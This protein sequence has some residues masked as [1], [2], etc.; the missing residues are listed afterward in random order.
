VCA[1]CAA[2]TAKAGAG[3]GQCT[4][5]PAGTFAASS[6]S[7]ECGACPEDTYADTLGATACSRC[8]TGS[9]TSGSEGVDSATEC[10]CAGEFYDEHLASGLG[11]NST[12]AVPRCAAC[13]ACVPGQERAVVPCSPSSN[14][15][16]ASRTLE[17]WPVRSASGSASRGSLSQSFADSKRGPGCEVFV[18]LEHSTNSR[19]D[20]AVGRAWFRI[21]QTTPASG[22]PYTLVFLADNHRKYRAMLGDVSG[23]FADTVS[24]QFTL[25]YLRLSGGQLSPNATDAPLATDPRWRTSSRTVT[26]GASSGVSAAG[27]IDQPGSSA[28]GWGSP[29]QPVSGPWRTVHRTGSRGRLVATYDNEQR[30]SD[31][32]V[33]INVRYYDDTGPAVGYFRLV[34]RDESQ[35]STAE[36]AVDRPIV[37]GNGGEATFS[38]GPVA[39][40]NSGVVVELWSLRRDGLQSGAYDWIEPTRWGIVRV[41]T[42][43][44]V[45]AASIVPDAG[46]NE[47]STS[48]T[49]ARARVIRLWDARRDSDG[50]ARVMIRWVEDWGPSRRSFLMRVFRANDRST[51][52]AERSLDLVNGFQ[53]VYTLPGVMPTDDID[54]VM[55]HE[56]WVPG[57]ANWVPSCSVRI[58]ADTP[59]NRVEVYPRIDLGQVINASVVTTRPSTQATGARGHLC[60]MYGDLRAPGCKVQVA[61]R[62][63]AGSGTSTCA[64]S[65]R[66][67]AIRV[68]LGSSAS[69]PIILD[70]A[71]QIRE[72]TEA[73]IEL[74]G[75]ERFAI[76]GSGAPRHRVELRYPDGRGGHRLDSFAILSSDCIQPF[77]GRAP[78]LVRL[79]E[80]GGFPLL[81]QTTDRRTNRNGRL[82]QLF[83]E[84]RMAD[85]SGLVGVNAM[86]LE[87]KPLGRGDVVVRVAYNDISGDDMQP[88]L[89]SSTGANAP[90]D[91]SQLLMLPR[92]SEAWVVFRSEKDGIS[93]SERP[94]ISL[95]RFD[96]TRD[97]GD[98]VRDG[99]TTVS[100][101]QFALGNNVIDH[102]VQWYA[103]ATTLDQDQRPSSGSPVLPL[104]NARYTGANG[105]MESI[106]GAARACDGSVLLRVTYCESAV[107]SP[108]GGRTFAVWEERSGTR[109]SVFLPNCRETA[110]V[111][112]ASLRSGRDLIFRLLRSD[113]RGGF[114][115]RGRT[116]AIMPASSDVCPADIMAAYDVVKA[117]L[118]S[119]NVGTG[120]GVLAGTSSLDTT[121]LDVHLQAGAVVT[122]S[123]RLGAI[124]NNGC[125]D[126]AGAS[127]FK[128]CARSLMRQL[129]AGEGEHGARRTATTESSYSNAA[130]A[131]GV[132]LQSAINSLA[133]LPAGTHVLLSLESFTASEDSVDAD[134]ELEPAPAGRRALARMPATQSGFTGRSL[135]EGTEG[136]PAQPVVGDA[137]TGVSDSAAF[138]VDEQAASSLSAEDSMQLDFRVIPASNTDAATLAV[139]QAVKDGTLEDA[140]RAAGGEITAL[141][142]LKSSPIA[143][144][145]QGI[146]AGGSTSS[147]SPAV[148][149]ASDNDSPTPIG[150]VLAASGLL[151]LAVAVAAVT[152]FRRRRAAGPAREDSAAGG[153][154]APR[155]SVVNR[156]L[157]RVASA[158]QR[159]S[160]AASAPAPRLAP[161]RRAAS[162]AADEAGSARAPSATAA[163]HEPIMTLTEQMAMGSDSSAPARRKLGPTRVVKVSTGAPS[164]G[165]LPLESEGHGPFSAV[166]TSHQ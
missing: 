104:P 152:A 123:R 87:Q 92:G 144:R 9:T 127:E 4:V 10:A 21:T 6:G 149:A 23:D 165:A 12:P 126:R 116:V 141:S 163:R 90:A 78:E 16:C 86:T 11:G 122:L 157:Q 2:G 135:Q 115:A 85:N 114:V 164:G 147:S 160:T 38:L 68:R 66:V 34:A 88:F 25:A 67:F 59:D 142:F 70:A 18:D 36:P 89:V 3:A 73:I 108:R 43:R 83:G 128:P 44:R 117:G 17:G 57:R 155:H 156:I 143:S 32:S 102:F 22:S 53:A 19:P 26:V 154:S 63:V 98:G 49:G 138:D 151:A 153:H 106:P 46:T 124:L 65:T 27:C 74:G 24:F 56:R 58:G 112:P 62:F 161:G 82:D 105:R 71:V 109:R 5:C 130:S 48:Q 29:L 121:V 166:G 54:V 1:S 76:H 37:V 110:I 159:S 52:L 162:S 69:S 60:G 47:P 139:S 107:S 8:P 72:G 145:V 50:A 119:E 80:A 81:A 134:D 45:S 77:K 118:L 42:L 30:D 140:I 84:R 125:R 40:C 91:A 41:G 100:T 79:A 7:A 39:C 64:G 35:P 55:Y 113:G 158:M 51:P 33:K 94:R 146:G 120:P 132:V 103:A 28:G 137:G 15:V 14:R 133:T 99:W 20:G 131:A 136:G 111:F 96:P 61:V 101:V 93:Y 31:G 97:S 148:T 13:Q 150:W 75:A 129:S 95:A